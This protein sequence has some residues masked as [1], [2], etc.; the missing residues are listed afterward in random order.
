VSNGENN[1][2]SKISTETPWW[3]KAPVWLA[4]GIVGVPSF[5]AIAAGYF[6][7]QG[8]SKTLHDNADQARHGVLVIEKLSDKIDHIQRENQQE[9]DR[10]RAFMLE[11]LRV[12]MRTCINEAK[13]P[14]E[15]L[16]CIRATNDEASK[17]NLP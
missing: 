2:A 11:R 3:A 7:V 1:F 6:I 4:A 15:R 5:I 16:D 17:L 9:W 14:K 13:D 10:V 8:V 12:E